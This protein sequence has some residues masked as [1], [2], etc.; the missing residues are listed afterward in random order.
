MATNLPYELKGTLRSGFEVDKAQL[1]DFRAL[2]SDWREIFR[3]IMSIAGDMPYYDENNKI[4]GTMA[5]LWHN[6]VLTVLVEIRQKNLKEY[7]TSFV[8]GNGTAQQNTYTADLQEKINGWIDRL[9]IYLNN[10]FASGTVS[11]SMRVAENIREQ[12][13]KSLPIVP[14]PTPRRRNFIHKVL[15]ENNRPY[16]SMLGALSDIQSKF[17]SYMQQIESSG[18]M[19]ASQA[20]LLT[21]V[22]SYCRIVRQF[23][24]KFADLPDFYRREILKATPKEAVQDST[25]VVVNPNKEITD[26]TFSLPAGTRFNAGENADGA[27]LYYSL[28]EKSYIVQTTIKSARTI[29]PQGS[30]III[31]PLALDG[32]ENNTLFSTTNPANAPQELGWALSSPM[33]SLAEGDRKVEVCF[34]MCGRENRPVPDITPLLASGSPFRLFIS[35]SEGWTERAHTATYERAE[36]Y[37]LFSFI[38]ADGE[39]ALAPCNID[40]HGIETK[41]PAVRILVDERPVTGIDLNEVMFNDVR[42]NVSVDGIR[43][44]SLYSDI[45]EMDSL[46]PFYPFGTAGEKGSWFIFGSEELSIKKVQNITLKG[47]W[48]KLPD[49]G[50]TALYRNYALAQP[51]TDSSFKAICEWQENSRWNVCRNSPIQLFGIDALGKIKEDAEFSLDIGAPAN[52][53]LGGTYAY[54]KKANGFYRI[55]L[56]EPGIGFG[57]EIYRNRFAEVMMHN[58]KAKE[59]GQKAVPAMPQIPMITDAVLG[60][61]AMDSFGEDDRLY[62]INEIN[63]YEPMEMIAGGLQL[64]ADIDR[65][66]LYIDL[67][68]VEPTQ[69]QISLYLNISYATGK[70]LA[71]TSS[72][73]EDS[74]VVEYYNSEDHKWKH[75]PVENILQDDTRALT[76]NGHIVFSLLDEAD[77]HIATGRNVWLRLSLKND[78]V[79]DNVVVNDIWLNCFKV[80]CENGDGLPL[81][82][83]T[84]ASLAEDEPRVSEVLQ[85]M[86]GYG[87][88]A[89]EDGHAMSVR[90]AIRIATR[91]RALNMGD[92]EKMI[93]ERF[94]DVEKVCCIPVSGSG[95][96]VHVVV[97]PK[98]EPGVLPQLPNWKLD[99]IEQ[100]IKGCTSPFAKVRIVNPAYDPLTVRMIVILKDLVQDEGEVQRRLCKR[101]YRYFVSW[102]AKGE[103]PELGRHYSYEGLKAW[104]VNDEGIERCVSLTITG[105]K[106]VTVSDDEGNTEDVYHFSSIENGILYPEKIDIEMNY[107]GDGIGDSG[108]GTNFI[109]G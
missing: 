49:G 29:F 90:T 78:L 2:E 65:H 106:S 109:I 19:D 16:F 85:P 91:N 74:L 27:P 7:A 84:I 80:I 72:A 67:A 26:K 3:W 25:Y 24:D 11:Q 42:I 76:R 56:S 66:Y 101:I 57:M 33:L 8:D 108:I 88:K 52:G 41:Y 1:K 17:D 73:E 39:E 86:D 77:A 43:S 70:G 50:Y 75:L 12:L 93:L 69:Q 92:Y 45:G 51:V 61:T 81:P 44:F 104:L 95:N 22:R 58:S 64:R 100:Y 48:N 13:R 62:R 97:F 14:Q 23:N 87:G 103:L 55:R 105:G 28:T 71:A 47:T 63:G 21:F 68:D 10:A 34:V 89:A 31:A 30:K 54:N 98:P 59:K 82:A 4:S 38:I 99:E 46:Q 18:D 20:L 5:A 36:N 35:S 32:T 15:E 9:S 102:L 60:Y 107:S 79:T 83:G 6:D 96:E 37:L 53:R 40:I 94:G